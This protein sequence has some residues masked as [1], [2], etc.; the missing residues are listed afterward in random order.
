MLEFHPPAMKVMGSIS[1]R[2]QFAGNSEF[3]P[4]HTSASLAK[5]ALGHILARNLHFEAL[6]RY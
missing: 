4:C 2:L 5:L 1:D 3:M 6:G